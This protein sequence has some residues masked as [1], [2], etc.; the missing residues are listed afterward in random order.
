MAREAD[1]RAVAQRDEHATG[2]RANDVDLGGP[3]G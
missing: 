1:E 3:R 2:S